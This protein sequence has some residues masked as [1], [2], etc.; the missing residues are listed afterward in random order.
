MATYSS[1]LAWGIPWSE[2]PAGYGLWGRKES[3]M[4]E[5][6]EHTA[7][8]ENLDDS[9][10]RLFKLCFTCTDFL[11]PLCLLVEL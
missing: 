1:I 5:V 4:T 7:C 6:T 10:G 2:E 11:S 8:S 3:D 9:L